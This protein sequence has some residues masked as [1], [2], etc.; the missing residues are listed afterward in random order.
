MKLWIHPFV[1]DRNHSGV[2]SKL[3]GDLRKYRTKFFNYMRMSLEAFDELLE[4]CRNYLMKQDT[5]LQR[6][7][8]P[9]EK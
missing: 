4:L 1:S 5:V 7:I 6:S 9:E 8:G 2:L 3:Y